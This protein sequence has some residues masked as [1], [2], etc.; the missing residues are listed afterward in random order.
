MKIFTCNFF[1]VGRTTGQLGRY[2]NMKIFSFD[3]ETN[4]LYGQAF[5]IAAVVGADDGSEIA[6][7]LGRCPIKGPVNPWVEENVLPA[8]A[9]IPVTCASYADLLE[10]FYPFYMTHKKDADV[11]AAIPYPVETTILRDMITAVPSRDF[12]GPY[13]LIDIASVLKAKGHNPLSEEDYIRA[14]GLIVPFNG[15]AHH[16]LYDSWAGLIAY[17]HVMSNGHARLVPSSKDKP[18]PTP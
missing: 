18:R 8:V 7:F 4:G 6:N 15:R 5:I 17:R 12:D 2:Y 13:P 14:N 1:G 9:D 10:S 16:P 3:G 11:I